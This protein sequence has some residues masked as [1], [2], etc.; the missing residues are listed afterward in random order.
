MIK[1]HETLLSAG[2]GFSAGIGFVR[3][4]PR[5]LGL[6]TQA[7]RIPGREVLG[8]VPH[9]WHACRVLGAQFRLCAAGNDFCVPGTRSRVRGPMKIAAEPHSAVSRWNLDFVGWQGGYRAC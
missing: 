8:A 5:P 2:A 3:V 1:P 6:S 9:A 4:I 7:T